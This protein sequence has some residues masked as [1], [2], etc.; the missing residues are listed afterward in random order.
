M[1]RNHSKVIRARWIVPVSSS[2]I[3]NA[4][5]R[6]SDGKITEVGSGKPSGDVL[7]LGDVAL[8]P[9]L[10]NSHTHLEFSD[11][12]SP[13]GYPG[14]AFSEWIKLVIASRF[15][16]D[17]SQKVNNITLGSNELWNTGTVLAAEIATP[18]FDYTQVKSASEIITFAEV[19][20]IEASR[21]EERL[22]SATDHLEHHGVGGFSPHSPY[23]LSIEA[24]GSV[25]EQAKAIGKPVAMHL[26]ESPDERELLSTGR[27]QLSDLL[28]SMGLQPARHFPWS[29][30]PFEHVIHLFSK[31]PQALLVHG[32]DLIDSEIEYLSHFSNISVVFC[33]RT[34]HFFGFSNHPVEKML[35]AGIRVVLGTDSRASN[36]DLNLWHEVQF[37]LNH[38]Q[39]IEP[40]KVLEMATLVPAGIFRG[41]L[42]RQDDLGQLA[43][44]F[45]AQ[46]GAVATSSDNVGQ[47]YDDLSCNSYQNVVLG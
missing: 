11:C 9:R 19:L 36:P 25:L 31:L 13:I 44:G 15:A 12:K 45:S 47:L 37:V 41:L 18:P 32:N 10:I 24:L 28:K 4:W 1:S 17:P 21:F 40:S 14:I 7:D 2:P 33:P 38:Y 22:A 34:H 5:V 39:Q 23:S 26:A 6:V 27:G 20:G 35:R 3:A 42:T 16:S 29:V 30:N 8:L 43:A 46:M